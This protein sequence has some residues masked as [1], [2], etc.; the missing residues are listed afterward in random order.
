MGNQ[1]SSNTMYHGDSS[2]GLA[3]TFTPLSRSD[4][5]IFGIIRRKSSELLTVFVFALNMRS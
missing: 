5:T 3:A 4:F 1:L 2:A